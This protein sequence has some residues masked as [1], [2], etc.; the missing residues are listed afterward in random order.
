MFPNLNNIFAMRINQVNNNASISY[1][2]SVQQEHQS[3]LKQNAG[4]WQPGDAYGSPQ[5]YNNWN[6]MNDPDVIDQPSS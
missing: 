2:P 4:F 1:G 5:L 6:I 3:N